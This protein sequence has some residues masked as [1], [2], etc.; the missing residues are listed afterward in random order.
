MAP[1][2]Y[3]IVLQSMTKKY[4]PWEY[5]KV[6]YLYCKHCCLKFSGSVWGKRWGP[7]QDSIYVSFNIK[8]PYMKGILATSAAFVANGSCIGLLASQLRGFTQILEWVPFLSCPSVSLSQDYR[9][10][11]PCWRA[12]SGLCAC[13]VSTLS[14][15]FHPFFNDR[16]TGTVAV[17]ADSSFLCLVLVFEIRP[18]IAAQAGLKLEIPLPLAPRCCDY[19]HTSVCLVQG[20]E[21]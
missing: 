6:G 10:V 12:I 17:S 15:D 8:H 3:L 14:R 11:P 19:R 4:S 20:P 13:W 1:E 7:A 16:S 18:C 21:K 5:R 9:Q 2:G